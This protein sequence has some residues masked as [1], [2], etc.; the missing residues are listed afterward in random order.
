MRFAEITEGLP[1]ES[2]ETC[3]VSC[4]RGG[5]RGGFTGFA[6]TTD[7]FHGPSVTRP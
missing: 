5:M 6:V 2:F 4:H 7:G 1:R 3:K